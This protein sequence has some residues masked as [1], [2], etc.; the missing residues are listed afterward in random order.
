MKDM[1]RRKI[2][3]ERGCMKSIEPKKIF[4]LWGIVCDGTAFFV[5]VVFSSAILKD[6]KEL[7]W[8]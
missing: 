7:I 1:Q 6:T 3:R 2:V 4:Q 8:M 5:V